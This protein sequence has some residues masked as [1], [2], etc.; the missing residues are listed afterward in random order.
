MSDGNPF[1]SQFNMGEKWKYTSTTHKNELPIPVG[2]PASRTVASVNK[3]PS[4]INWAAAAKAAA[5]S[6]QVAAAAA[7]PQVAA[8]AA[9]P[10]V[11][12]AAASPQGLLGRGAGRP[13]LAPM[14]LGKGRGTPAAVLASP[15]A[16]VQHLATTAAAGGSTATPSVNDPN[17]E[18][19]GNRELIDQCI[20]TFNENIRQGARGKSGSFGTTLKLRIGAENYFIKRIINTNYVYLKKEIDFA[21]YLTSTNPNYVS[22]LKGAF[23][24]KSVPKT[25]VAFLIYEAPDGMVLNEY[26]ERFPPNPANPNKIAIYN[27]LYCL[28]AIAKI[29]INI[30]GVVHRDIKPPNIYV[31][32][33]HLGNP[34]ACKLF[35]FGLSDRIGDRFLAQGS[36]LYTPVEMRPNENRPPTVPAYSGPVSSYHNDYSVDVIWDLDFRM[37]G[38]AKPDCSAVLAR[39]GGRRKY[40]KTRK[41]RKNR[42]ILKKT[43]KSKSS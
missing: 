1:G 15:L 14:V 11:A 24:D 22:I 39:R 13:P 10:Q 20:H 27:K 21:V 2:V 6:P 42:R 29:A 16:Q 34:L 19:Y 23:I 26:I 12:A 40:K 3:P 5:A 35:D 37:A 31:I 7:S 4:K 8:A 33:D 18:Y 17:K 32:T 36:P 30:S 43:R 9:S 25:P 28:I 38:I 41:N